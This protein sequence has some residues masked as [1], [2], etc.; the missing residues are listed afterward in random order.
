[1]RIVPTLVL[2]GILA[3]IWPNSS[4][5]LS[6]MAQ[7]LDK[8]FSD[9]N[10]VLIIEPDSI[11]NTKNSSAATEFTWSATVIERFKGPNAKNITITD[12]V[13]TGGLPNGTSRLESNVPYLVFLDAEGQMGMCDYP[14]DVQREPLTTEEQTILQVQLE[15]SQQCTPY[16]CTDGTVFP[17]C[18]DTGESI[19]Y[20][21]PPC[22]ANGGQKGTSTGP[23]TF[24]DVSDAHPYYEAITWAKNN[25][26]VEGYSDGTFRPDALI[27]R[28]EF[29]KIL[30]G[31]TEATAL[32]SCD[33]KTTYK[34]VDTRYN[35]W[36]SQYLCIAVQNQYASGDP[37]GTF[38]PSANINAAEAAKIIVRKYSNGSIHQSATGDWYTPFISYLQVRNALPLTIHYADQKITRSEMV[39]ILYALEQY[40]TMYNQ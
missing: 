18:T 25:G 16:E 40:A 27:N 35:E 20:F 10:V 39:A 33:A 7:S 1:M 22:H 5:A 9:A 11:I 38:R 4:Y 26:I 30:L 14:R 8:R 28:V 19:M 3:T 12:V 37:T 36:Y 17:A 13:W 32:A 2:A 34:F 15:D 24:S 6:C 29:L 31:K 21:A 23:N